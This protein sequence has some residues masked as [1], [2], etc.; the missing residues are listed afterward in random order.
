MNSHRFQRGWILAG[1]A[2]VAATLFFGTAPHAFA[3]FKKGDKATVNR[4]A[5]VME[6]HTTKGAKLSECKPN[7]LRIHDPELS[8][9]CT[10]I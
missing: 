2:V 3:A 1:I 9:T 5:R 6:F 7:E 10:P 4:R 8:I